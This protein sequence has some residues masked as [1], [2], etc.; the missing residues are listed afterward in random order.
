MLEPVPAYHLAAGELWH[1]AMLGALAAEVLID[2]STLHVPPETVSA[3]LLADIGKVVL[4]RCLDQETLE[5]LQRAEKEGHQSR[6]QAELEMLGAHHGEI[7]A[8][9]AQHWAL[10]Q[11]IV[12]GILYH[13]TPEDSDELVAYA[14][15]LSCAV[16]DMVLAGLAGA[17]D[18]PSLPEW[19]EK[20]GIVSE[21][22][23]RLCE[24]TS[25]RY[26]ELNAKV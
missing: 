13:H 1:T 6:H 22:I 14:T 7:G 21:D 15:S 18:V 10:P 19:M 5:Y 12:T 11:G 25:A 4:S 23:P 20:I 9:V 26:D 2:Y 3:A 17:E 8:L 16:A 24:A